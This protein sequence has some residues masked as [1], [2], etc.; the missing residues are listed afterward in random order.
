MGSDDQFVTADEFIN[1]Y[2]SK[3]KQ[4]KLKSSNGDN[5]KIN[6]IHNS[7]NEFLYHFKPLEIAI[8]LDNLLSNSR[9]AKATEITITINNTEKNLLVV[10]FKDN[11][12]GITPNL[13]DK[14]FD[15]GFTTTSGSGLGL[16]NLKNIIRI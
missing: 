16:F 9:K 3:V 13:F 14:I 4:G 8:V 1:Q 7:K 15:F 5:M 11:G 10:S 2:I 6:I 12:I